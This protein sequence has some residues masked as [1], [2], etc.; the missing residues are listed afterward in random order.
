[1][2]AMPALGDLE[3]RVM[4]ALWAHDEPQ[5]VRAVHDDIVAERD[6]AYTTILTVL[7]RLAKK[8]R[9]KRTR[10]G[11]AWLY[12]PAAS[13][14]VMVAEAL[15]EELND[16]ADERAEALDEFVQRLS[17]ADVETLGKLLRTVRS[18]RSA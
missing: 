6:L 3:M 5:S 15:V 7:D 9:V 18:V 16:A 17:P 14:A 12:S 1:M 13:R 11:R 4:E 2:G 10:S 8:G